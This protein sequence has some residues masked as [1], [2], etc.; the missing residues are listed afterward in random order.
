MGHVTQFVV[1]SLPGQDRLSLKFITVSKQA[2]VENGWRKSWQGYWKDQAEGS[3]K[4]CQG[5]SAV[6]SWK[7]KDTPDILQIIVAD[8]CD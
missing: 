2:S 3:V 7:V 1:E 8:M 5:W 4:I 6:P